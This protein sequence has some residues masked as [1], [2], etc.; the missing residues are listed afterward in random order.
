MGVTSSTGSTQKQFNLI[1]PSPITKGYFEMS[2][3]K[4]NSYYDKVKFTLFYYKASE[5]GALLYDIRLK[6]FEKNIN[7]YS[8]ISVYV[9][10]C[11][12]S[13]GYIYYSP[14]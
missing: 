7:P 8:P 14:Y 4:V 3:T 2:Q 5:G 10:E 11:S 6:Q 13:R 1:T 12:F 9:K